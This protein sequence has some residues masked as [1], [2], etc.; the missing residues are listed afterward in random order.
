MYIDTDTERLKKVLLLVIFL[1]LDITINVIECLL[2]L[3]VFLDMYPMPIFKCQI[4][5]LI[6]WVLSW[7]LILNLNKKIAIFYHLRF[8]ILCQI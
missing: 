6:L 8:Y 1:R 3:S 2:M 4:S 5:D 7:V